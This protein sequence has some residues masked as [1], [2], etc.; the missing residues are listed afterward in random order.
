MAKRRYI[1]LKDWIICLNRGKLVEIDNR[2]FSNFNPDTGEIDEYYCNAANMKV[3]CRSTYWTWDW[4]D[5][6]HFEHETNYVGKLI[7][8]DDDLE[9]LRKRAQCASPC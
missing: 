9:E 1:R 6:G 4:I 3:M 5:C 2:R 7:D 8:T